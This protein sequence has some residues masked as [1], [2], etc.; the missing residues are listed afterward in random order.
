MISCRGMGVQPTFSTSKPP[1]TLANL[2]ASARD[3]RAEA[4]TDHREH[5]VARAGDVVHGSGLRRIDFAAAVGRDQR[6][7]VAIERDDAEVELMF[8]GQLPPGANRI[9]GRFNLDAGREFRFQAIRGHRRGTAITR[10]V[11]AA[12]RVDDH[13][14]AE[15]GAASIT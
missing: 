7:A 11:G 13:R 8:T 3:A 14:L 9:V 10:V 2:T 15:F 6:H 5:H 1:A 12:N 4:E